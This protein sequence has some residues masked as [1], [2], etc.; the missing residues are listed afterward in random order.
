M[1]SRNIAELQTALGHNFAQLE[2]L[3]RAL[4]HTSHANEMGIGKPDHTD[5]VRDNEQ[6]EFL[7]D[8]VLGLV[9]T[10]ELFR[11]FPSFRE[12]KLSKLRSQLVSERNLAL[13]AQKLNLGEYLYLGRG[14]EKSGGRNKIAILADALE[15]VLAAI[16][17][18]GGP[19][20]ARR[21]IVEQI[22]N[23]EIEHIKE[24]GHGLAVHDYKSALQEKMQ[25]AGRSQP[26]YT[27]V[28]A[29]GPEH[30]KTFTVEVRLQLTPKGRKRELAGRAEGTTKKNA[31]Q[32]AARLALNFLALHQ[33][34][35][36]PAA[37]R[38]GRT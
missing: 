9:T 31:E 15:A 24:N 4:T 23:P 27:L 29:R 6:L 19:E 37:A 38:K 13:V 7:G 12:G 25:A 32:E 21:V 10:E 16:Y 11:Q 28:S 17:L 33:M 18:D 14:E 26:V 30:S 36:P 5:E 2:L 1:T 8:A 22:V 35:T 3:Q 34:E 20:S